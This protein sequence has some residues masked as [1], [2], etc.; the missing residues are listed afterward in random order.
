[1]SKHYYLEQAGIDFNEQYPTFPEG[2]SREKEWKKQ[3]N[4]YGFDERDTWNLN[5]VLMMFIFE[6]V[7]MFNEFNCVDT[8]F[9][10][11]EYCGEEITFQNAIDRIIEGSKLYLEKDIYDILTDEEDKKINDVLPLFNLFL[12]CFWW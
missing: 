12:G 9:H 4:K 10:E 7:S 5:N 2:D 11:A 1:M 3:R 6:R 8:N